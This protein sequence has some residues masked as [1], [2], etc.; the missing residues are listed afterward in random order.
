LLGLSL[1]LRR[2]VHRLLLMVLS[3]GLSGVELTLGFYTC[4]FR[5]GCP[6]RF[7]SRETVFL[8]ASDGLLPQVSLVGTTLCFA[9]RLKRAQ[10]HEHGVHVLWWRAGF[11]QRCKLLVQRANKDT[12][13]LQRKSVP[14]PSGAVTGNRCDA[15]QHVVGDGASCHDLAPIVAIASS[16]GR[17][18][19][20]EDQVGKLAQ[21]F[22]AHRVLLEENWR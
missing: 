22:V 11:L 16:T 17:S 9:G 6:L 7:E 10:L 15:R 12:G 8:A 19:L 21:P 4:Q 5:R 3:R 14:W 1:R 20:E 13:G 18:D 2:M